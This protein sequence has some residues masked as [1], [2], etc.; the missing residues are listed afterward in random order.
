MNRYILTCSCHNMNKRALEAFSLL[1]PDKVAPEIIRGRDRIA[2]FAQSIQ[3]D[4]IKAISRLSG[5]FAYYVTIEDG[6]IVEEWDLLKGKRI[7]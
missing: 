7:A 6:K 5:R 1:F 2:K 3:N 4:H